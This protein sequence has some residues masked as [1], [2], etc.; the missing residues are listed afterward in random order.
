[1]LYIQ[2]KSY[3][4]KHSA[5]FEA[6]ELNASQLRGCDRRKQK[7]TAEMDDF[8]ELNNCVESDDYEHLPPATMQI[9]II[10]YGG[11]L[12]KSTR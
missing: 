7:K 12:S 8:R 6:N 9:Q 11:W 1:M 4:Y 3:N 2:L 5:G 10:I